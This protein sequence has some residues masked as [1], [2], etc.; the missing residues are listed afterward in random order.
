MS[1]IGWAAAFGA[2]WFVLVLIEDS[3]ADGLAAAMAIIILFGAALK[4]APD[5]IA[6][7]Q[8][9]GKGQA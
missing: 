4:L 1:G 5:A 2:T 9:I 3:G 8:N 7:L 6:N